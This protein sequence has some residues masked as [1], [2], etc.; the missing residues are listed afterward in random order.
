MQIFW[1]KRT[2]LGGKWKVFFFAYN[3]I[4]T[5]VAENEKDQIELF[6]NLITEH[7]TFSA[8]AALLINLVLMHFSRT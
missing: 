6:E 4:S 8:H 7:F 3:R 1:V 5:I 2:K